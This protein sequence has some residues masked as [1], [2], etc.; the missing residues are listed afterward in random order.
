M[1]A[2]PTAA[3]ELAEML[4]AQCKRVRRESTI[5]VQLAAQ[6]EDELTGEDTN[7]SPEEG[8]DDRHTRED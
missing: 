5:A 1:P 7:H 2:D 4:R 6:L 8:T 3:R